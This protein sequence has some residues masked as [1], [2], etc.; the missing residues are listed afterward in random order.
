LRYNPP[1]RALGERL[2]Q[3]GKHKLAIIGA[4]MH[5]LMR[6]AFGILKNREPFNE[7]HL[8]RA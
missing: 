8:A 1:V 7:N 6:I 4:A 5:K 3:R 2:A